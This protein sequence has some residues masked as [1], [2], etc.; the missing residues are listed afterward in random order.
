LQSII[1]AVI[2]LQLDQANAKNQS[3]TLQMPENTLNALI[4]EDRITQVVTNLISNAINYTPEG[5]HITVVLKPFDEE[6]A[7]IRVE[8]TG[9]GIP[10]DALE[11]IFMPFYRADNVQEHGTGLGL[12]I[13]KQIVE[14]H[15]GTILVTSEL[16][17]GSTFVV[18]LPRTRGDTQEMKKVK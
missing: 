18:H 5:G 9:L 17:K 12:H 1:E 14:L 2:E 11:H 16:G 15:K 13:T 8:D 7:E 6:F 3:L 4:D 10:P